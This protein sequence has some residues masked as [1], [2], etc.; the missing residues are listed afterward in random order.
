MALYVSYHSWPTKKFRFQMVQKGQN[1]VRNYKVLAKLLYQHFQI[2]SIFTH[3][4]R[5]PMKS[6]QFFKI[7]KHFDKEREKTLM[8]QSMRKEKLRKVGLCFIKGC[9][10]KSFNMIINHFFVSQA[11]SQP[12]FCFLISGWRKKY[13]KGK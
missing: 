8:Q 9:F 10:I 1:N 2:F 6:Y 11:H 5:L 7:C 12:N 13:Q 3:S 4:G